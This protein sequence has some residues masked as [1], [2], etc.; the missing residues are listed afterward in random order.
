[1]EARTK[2]LESQIG[3]MAKKLDRNPTQGHV[4]TE[5][6]LPFSRQITRFAISGKFKQPY[7][8]SYNGS[9]SLV[10]HVW[11]YKAQMALATNIHELLYLAFP[12]TLKGPTA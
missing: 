11:T 4:N 5:T 10:D 7:L 8:N 6:E 1:M 9:R 3:G 2:D 12:S